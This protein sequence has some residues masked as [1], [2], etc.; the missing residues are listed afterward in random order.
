MKREFLLIS[1]LLLNIGFISAQSEIKYYD[2]NLNEISGFSKIGEGVNQSIDKMEFNFEYEK[3][4]VKEFN[5]MFMY[6]ESDEN[7]STIYFKPFTNEPTFAMAF[8]LENLKK[9]I[10]FYNLDE[11]FSSWKFE[12]LLDDAIENAKTDKAVLTL[13]YF[14]VNMPIQPDKKATTNLA[15]EKVIRL[16]YNKYKVSLFFKD[17]VLISYHKN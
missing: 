4:I 16:D 5:V 14:L 10:H 9:Q 12:S 11:F 13:A 2:S 15:G 17:E 1:I 8:N 7:I 3:E 6:N